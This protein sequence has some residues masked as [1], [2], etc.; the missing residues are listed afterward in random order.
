MVPSGA[1]NFTQQY[2]RRNGRAPSIWETPRWESPG[3]I[4]RKRASGL[5]R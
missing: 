4:I 5:L 2:M 1:D 3:E